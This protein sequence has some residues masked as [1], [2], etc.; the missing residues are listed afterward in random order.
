MICCFMNL[1]EKENA[2]DLEKHFDKEIEQA[3]DFGCSTFVAGTKYP[4]DKIFRERVNKIAKYYKEGQIKFVA[5][6]NAA[7]A[8][9][10]DILI[11][12]ASWEIYS[13]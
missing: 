5:I 1:H 2:C 6:E 7:D 13:Y 4:E 10:T 3:I 9:L 8:E 11:K 12:S